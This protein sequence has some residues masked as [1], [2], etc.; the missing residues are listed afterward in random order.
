MSSHSASH[1]R[2]DDSFEQ[3]VTRIS[4]DA[5]A[6]FTAEQLNALKLAFRQ[7]NWKNH[8]LI[9]IRLTIPLFHRSLYVVLLAGRDRRSV[10]RRQGKPIDRR[11]ALT[12]L[13]TFVLLMTISLGIIYEVVQFAL[14]ASQRDN[15][16]P[17]AI[18]W[19]QTQAA[20]EHTGRL[21]EEGTCWD[22]VQS[23]D[24]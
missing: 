23:P 13:A 18:P 21:W 10:Q 6:T 12:R 2:A 11:K 19:L 8:H 1:Q 3:I 9:D 15:I 16:H 14:A 24:F 20:C 4:P 17:T 7:V 22:S 5:R